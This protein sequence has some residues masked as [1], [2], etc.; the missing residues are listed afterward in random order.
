V[1]LAADQNAPPIDLEDLAAPIMPVMNAPAGQVPP[2]ERPLTH[3][4]V[5][6]ALRRCYHFLLCL[7]WGGNTSMYSQNRLQKGGSPF[8]IFHEWKDS[9]RDDRRGNAIDL[10]FAFKRMRGKRKGSMDY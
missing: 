8:S 9:R 10:P 2:R 3:G 5:G 1:C 7:R 4:D 6:V